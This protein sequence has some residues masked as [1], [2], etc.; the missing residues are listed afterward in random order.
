LILERDYLQPCLGERSSQPPELDPFEIQVRDRLS[1]LG[2]PTPTGIG[3]AIALPFAFAAGWRR[4]WLLGAGVGA[5][6]VGAIVLTGS[7]GPLLAV[8]AGAV[9]AVLVR[10]QLNRRLVLGLA[11]AGIL[12]FCR[13]WVAVTM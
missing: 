11:G 8:A 5:L 7:R 2:Y 13:A 6:I 10:G 3:L 12:S 1:A 4:H 9:V